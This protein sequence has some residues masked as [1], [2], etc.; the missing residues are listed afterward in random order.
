MASEE[1]DGLQSQVGIRRGEKLKYE[2]KSAQT[3]AGDSKLSP[4]EIS[5][6]P[7]A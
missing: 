1:L 4:S 5:P 2:L 6:N 3:W 7:T